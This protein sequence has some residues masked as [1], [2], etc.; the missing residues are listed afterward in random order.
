MPQQPDRDSPVFTYHAHELHFP[1]TH[2]FDRHEFRWQSFLGEFVRPI[3]EENPTLQCAVSYYVDHAELYVYTDDFSLIQHCIDKFEQRGFTTKNMNR[4]LEENFG[5]GR[6][7]GPDSESDPTRRAK[8]IL[9]SLRALCDLLV[10]S[11]YKCENGY[12]DFESN[13]DK[14]N[15]PIGNHFYSILHLHHLITQTNVLIYPLL[16]P[17]GNVQLLD[18]YTYVNNHQIFRAHKLMSAPQ[19]CHP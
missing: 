2:P 6:F 15:N 16:T 18:Y 1:N 12:W 8:L 19:Q 5:S 14:A 4:T 9:A 10:D 7:L 11:V 17:D 13:A 3:L